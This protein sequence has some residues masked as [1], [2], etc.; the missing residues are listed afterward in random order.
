VRFSGSHERLC[1]YLLVASGNER[2]GA[3]VE[4][5][6]HGVLA[7]SPYESSEIRRKARGAPP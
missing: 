2:S 3:L 7:F 4:H 1:T 6:G 5:S